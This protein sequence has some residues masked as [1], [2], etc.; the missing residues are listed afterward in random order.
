M[1]D[2]GEGLH[3]QPAPLLT[4]HTHSL[5]VGKVRHCSVR[6]PSLGRRCPCLDVIDE[7]GAVVNHKCSIRHVCSARHT[8]QDHTSQPSSHVFMVCGQ[9]FETPPPTT[10]KLD[11]CM[12]RITLD[13][14]IAWQVLH[15]VGCGAYVQMEDVT[16]PLMRVNVY[17]SAGDSVDP[18]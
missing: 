5:C 4:P 7:A 9:G 15:R 14:M 16:E 18:A 6:E 1:T 2:E 8:H 11:A 12:H 13:Q 3:V 17:D 10:M